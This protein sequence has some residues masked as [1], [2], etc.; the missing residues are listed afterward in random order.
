M[1]IKIQTNESKNTPHK[2]AALKSSM[3]LS[4]QK[5]NKTNL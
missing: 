2:K 1:K 4:G 3:P 5:I